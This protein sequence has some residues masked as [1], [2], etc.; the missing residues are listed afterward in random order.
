MQTPARRIEGPRLTQSVDIAAEPRDHR[1]MFI[2]LEGIDGSGTTTQAR[3]VSEALRAK[4]H[5]VLQTAQPSSGSMGSLAR[6]MLGDHEHRGHHRAHTLALAFAGDRLDHYD[7]V[8][9]PAL[10]QGKT[11]IC[12][13][14]L[15]SSWVYQSLDLPLAW[16]KSINQFAP[17]PD[18]TLLLEIDAD[19]AHARVQSRKGNEEIFDKL[20]LQ[21]RLAQ[22]YR[23]L[24]NQELG[25]PVRSVDGRARVEDL[26]E[27]L[28]NQILAAPASPR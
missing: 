27:T 2:A 3:R 10:A 24:A 16:V 17:W 18:L 19:T 28:V 1:S 15:L 8:I 5:E 4:G 14:Y 25:H 11:V 26:C 22:S 21:R 13:R 20:E 9:A 7:R 12:D 23:D 6:Q